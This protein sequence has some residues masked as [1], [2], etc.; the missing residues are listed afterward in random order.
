MS[1]RTQRQVID[2]MIDAQG[3]D[4]DEATVGGIIEMRTGLAESSG[5]LLMTQVLYSAR[6]QQNTSPEAWAFVTGLDLGFRLGV[7]A[8]AAMP[9]LDD[10]VT[11][12]RAAREPATYEGRRAAGLRGVALAAGRHLRGWRP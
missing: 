3:E 5:K 10:V 4:L 12:A 2:A 9:R 6:R 11:P 7:E 8:G 1:D